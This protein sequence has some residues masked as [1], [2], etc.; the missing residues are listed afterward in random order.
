MS[1]SFT[2]FFSSSCLY[3]ACLVLCLFMLRDWEHHS[4]HSLFLHI[5]ILIQSLYSLPLLN[6]PSFISSHVRYITGNI[7]PDFHHKKYDIIRK[8]IYIYFS[9]LLFSLSTQR[10]L[11]FFYRFSRLRFSY[12]ISYY[13][14]SKDFLEFISIRGFFFQNIYPFLL[15]YRENVIVFNIPTISISI[16]SK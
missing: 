3:S 15:S 5:F 6:P 2:L 16:S 8:E 13:I 7:S 14:Q 1:K 12:S 9:S 4:H 10:L 11:H